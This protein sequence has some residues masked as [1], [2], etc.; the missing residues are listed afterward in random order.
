M[1][2]MQKRT[3]WTCDFSICG[4]LWLDISHRGLGWWRWRWFGQIPAFGEA[5]PLKCAL[6][7]SRASSFF[8]A[9]EK[10]GKIEDWTCERSLKNWYKILENLKHRLKLLLYLWWLGWRRIGNSVFPDHCGDD[11]PKCNKFSFY[12]ARD[13]RICHWNAVLSQINLNTV[14]TCI[15]E[16]VFSRSIYY[17]VFTVF[18]RMYFSLSFQVPMSFNSEPRIIHRLRW[19]QDRFSTSS[20]STKWVQS[21]A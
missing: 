13:L 12:S 20:A 5:E 3:D 6:R 15:Y 21:I 16:R 4:Q 2:N 8:E 9:S 19:W 1:I 10:L 7:T 14:S 11:D 18:T 17:W